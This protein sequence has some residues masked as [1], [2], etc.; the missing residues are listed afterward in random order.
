M[1]A[2]GVRLAGPK[3]LPSCWSRKVDITASFTLLEYWGAEDVLTEHELGVLSSRT[4][5]AGEVKHQ[6]SREW[7]AILTALRHEIMFVFGELGVDLHKLLEEKH[8]FLAVVNLDLII[9]QVGRVRPQDWIRK[10]VHLDPAEQGL[11]VSCVLQES[12]SELFLDDRGVAA[13]I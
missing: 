8:I 12:D 3:V 13:D 2:N 10:G 5:I 4:G 6:R 9:G 1:I 7:S 11:L